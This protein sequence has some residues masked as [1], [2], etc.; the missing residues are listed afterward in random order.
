[1]TSAAMAQSSVTLYGIVDAGVNYLSS[2][3]TG[4]ST[5]GLV[6]HSQ[7]SIQD[8]TLGGLTGS[9]FGLRG[10]EDL[11]GG[12]SAIFQLES[13]F[14]LNNGALGQGSDFF[15]RQAW[16]GLR[17]NSLGT[18]TLGR[19]YDSVVSF[20]Q[21]FVS[22][23]Q[24]AGYIGAHPGDLDNLENT[25]RINSSVKYMSHD[26]HGLT[27]G[28]MYGV[29]GVPGST[30][31]N[32]VWSVG[33]GYSNGPLALGVGFLN[34]RNPNLSYFGTNPSAGT[35]ATSNNLGSLGSATTPQSNPIFA[36]YASAQSLQLV[37]AGGSYAIGNATLGATYT[38]TQFRDLGDT[39]T[40]GPN[41]FGYSGTAT[42]N[43]AELNFVYQFTPSLLAGVAYD[44]TH[45]S[46]A[47]GRSGAMYHQGAAGTDYFLSKRTDVYAIVVYQHAA[48]TDSLNQ[49]AV[50]DITGQTASATSHQLA[51]RIGLRHRF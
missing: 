34:A 19:Q 39:A 25:R 18:V 48:G 26:Y 51:V 4:R 45:S 14:S 9:R 22:A 1:M 10:A 30:G 29:G 28:G 7:Y 43:N 23:A 8:G 49:P 2:A 40:S 11:G 3:Q 21:P 6:G 5:S 36:G 41:P 37:A 44:Y 50:A 31:R 35:T 12:L 17:S 16:T 20:V 13:G 27:V 38:N 47:S 24:W 42:F 33:A 46:G 32:Q 15:G